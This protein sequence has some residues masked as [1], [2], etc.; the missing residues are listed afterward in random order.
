MILRN[1]WIIVIILLILIL[2]FFYFKPKNYDNLL[3][4]RKPTDDDLKS[5]ATMIKGNVT[6]P[7]YIIDNF[8]TQ[9]EC[10][11]LIKE[12]K[13]RLVPSPLTRQDPNDP[14]FRTSKTAYFQNS[15]IENKINDRI[16]KTMKLD[17][18]DGE[19]PQI[20]HYNVGEE[21]KSHWDAFDPKVDY[22]FWKEGQRTWTFMIYLNNV[23]DGG[24]TE[25]PKL[26]FKVKPKIGRVVVW[27]NL[28]PDGKLDRNTLH[29][30]MPIKAGTKTIVTKWFKLIKKS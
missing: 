3:P 23:Q 12:T 2:L 18:Q 10:N 26:N 29:R 9:E 30:G 1:K 8:M 28:T 7:I 25:F 11:L 13:E 19:D 15:Y 27:Y 16:L 22:D 14:Y 24:D 21:F 17:N 20:Q 4:S 5:I 6:T